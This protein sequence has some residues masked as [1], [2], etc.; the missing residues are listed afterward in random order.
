M[1]NKQIKLPNGNTLELSITPAFLEKVAQQFSFNSAQDVTDD[2][3]RLYLFG[4]L[5]TALDKAENDGIYINN[6]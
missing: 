3:I 1:E 4:A 5:K 2:H 6:S